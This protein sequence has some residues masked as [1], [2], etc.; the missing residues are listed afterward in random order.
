[1]LVAA[2]AVLAGIGFILTFVM[3]AL[4]EVECVIDDEM[5]RDDLD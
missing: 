1:M 4:C 3:L 5:N 2:I